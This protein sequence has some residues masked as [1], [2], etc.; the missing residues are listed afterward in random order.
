MQNIRN[1]AEFSKHFDFAPGIVHD[2]VKRLLKK[3]AINILDF[4]CNLGLK[5]LGVCNRFEVNEFLGCDL[6]DHFKYL[7]ENVKKFRPDLVIQDNIKFKQIQCG[8]KIADSF[9]ADLIFS[10][11]V[12]EHVEIGSMSVVLEDLYNVLNPDGVFFLQINPFYY[13][14]YGSHLGS[15]LSDPWL[16]LYKTY[17]ELHDEL[18][19][20]V[21]NA[22]YA[23]DLWGVYN[24]LNK[25]TFSE[26]KSECLKAGFK[27]H[28]EITGKTKLNI[29]KDLTKTV[30]KKDLS[31]EGC[32]LLLV[33]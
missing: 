3:S 7:A 29:P 17:E 32:Q 6:N 8:E 16:H 12:F 10:W 27:I 18:K 24:S 26:L 30:D 11:S 14:P 23:E 4:G 2:Q 19:N 9:K 25:I 22:N 1:E 31:I 20:A 13:S 15:V 21:S 28:G 33:K 5:G